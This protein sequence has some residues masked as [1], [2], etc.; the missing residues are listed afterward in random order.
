MTI[1][2][3][4]GNHVIRFLQNISLSAMRVRLALL[5]LLNLADYM[6]TKVLL[7]R[8]GFFEL[9]PLMAL[10]MQSAAATVV[11]KVLLPGALLLYLY[12]RMLF[13]GPNQMRTC[14]RV[15]NWLC[16]GYAAVNLMHLL[17][18]AGAW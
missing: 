13:A 14:A 9:N 16:A 7:S 18:F 1:T 6:L 8:G 5:Y 17:L 10:T 11:V 3:T 15:L 4:G 12:R 2:M